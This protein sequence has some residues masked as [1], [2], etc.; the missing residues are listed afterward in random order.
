MVAFVV[1]VTSVPVAVDKVLLPLL[2]VLARMV[3]LL[4][5]GVALFRLVVLE[6]LIHPNPAAPLVEDPVFVEPEDPPE[7]VPVDPFED[8]PAAV[9]PD[10]VAARPAVDRPVAPGLGLELKVK[11]LIVVR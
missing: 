9:D 2:V 6:P 11:P 3:A 4:L 1:V 10:P 5:G 7:V 8:D